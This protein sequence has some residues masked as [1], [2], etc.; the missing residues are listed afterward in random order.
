MQ[1]ESTSNA[2]EENFSQKNDHPAVTSTSSEVKKRGLSFKWMV[3]LTVVFGSFM[4][5]LD[6]SVTVV[7]LSKLQSVF[8]A[9]LNDLQWILTAYTLAQ[10]ISIPLAGYLAA[11]F[12]RKRIYQIA[13]VAFS[14]GSL[15]CGL[16]WNL[17]SLIS[18]RV[19]Q[20]LGGG[21]LAP[22]ATAMVFDAFPPQERGRGAAT[23]GVPLLIGPAIGPVLGGYLVQ[24]ISWR[25][26]FFI[27]LPISLVGFLMAWRILRERRSST[28]P[29]LDWLGITLSTIG[30]VSLFYGISQAATDSWS[31]AYVLG[32]TL[33]GL[34]SLVA[35]V[36]VEW[37]T[38]SPALDVRLFKDWAFTN[39]NGVAVILQFCFFGGFFL[40]PLYMENLR[41]VPAFEAG[42]WLMPVALAAAI[43]LP[44]SGI[45]V[46][47]FGAR[48]VIAF[49]GI[50][51]TFSSWWM[52][53][54]VDLST[55]LWT[56]LVPFIVRGIALA[57][58]LQ[59]SNVVSH[60]SI[61]RDQLPHASSL[62]AVL[63]A[64]AASLGTAVL[65]TFLNSREIIDQAH[66]ALPLATMHAFDEA[67]LLNT[68]VAAASVVLALS[69]PS[70]P[71][72]SEESE[73]TATSSSVQPASATAN[74]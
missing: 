58:V 43:T 56:L 4:T 68:V 14:V 55:P 17:G 63:S 40:F 54:Y 6:R 15:L 32:T 39:G 52:A 7:A 20:G 48:W 37:R 12:G 25:F 67:N 57:F 53:F 10:G 16:S 28:K 74:G 65:A 35:L 23:L 1:S 31:S 66:F 9:P 29:N 11:R 51:L 49:G 27:N 8:P 46:D 26:I 3:A 19:L 60:Q 44:I 72:S 33:V 50:A 62:R 61:P 69:L 71:K 41:G 21:A 2:K 45:L 42:L 24:Y 64:A 30:F 38:P 47:R 73:A 22:L 70:R 13:L 36:I 5:Q 18:F 34:V 59:P